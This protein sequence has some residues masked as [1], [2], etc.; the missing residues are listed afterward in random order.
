MTTVAKN[1]TSQLFKSSY[2]FVSTLALTDNEKSLNDESNQMGTD[3]DTA[4][5]IGTIK[6][7]S[8]A[9][10]NEESTQMDTNDESTNQNNEK[11]DDDDIQMIDDDDTS[12]HLK[13]TSVESAENVES[14][15][16]QSDHEVS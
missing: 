14:N 5:N 9:T 10:T 7:S 6:I 4:D 3:T 15:G 8:I 12:D 1:V 16:K 13:I 11:D 2:Y